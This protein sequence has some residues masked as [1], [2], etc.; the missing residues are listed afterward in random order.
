MLFIC[1]FINIWSAPVGWINS[2]CTDNVK[3]DHEAHWTRISN[4]EIH[5]VENNA[6][7][8]LS[9]YFIPHSLHSLNKISQDVPFLSAYFM[10]L[11]LPAPTLLSP[12]LSIWKISTLVLILTRMKLFLTF[13]PIFSGRL[14]Q[15]F[16]SAFSESDTYFYYCTYNTLLL[17]FLSLLDYKCKNWKGDE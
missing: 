10:W 4:F 5:R 1:V 12:T 8:S 17:L 13:F 14:Y 11:L 9:L 6:C 7:I 16:L 3:L 2:G 15:L